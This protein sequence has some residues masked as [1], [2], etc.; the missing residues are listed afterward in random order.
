MHVVGNGCSGLLLQPA[1]RRCQLT[2]FETFQNLIIAFILV[3]EDFSAPL[4]EQP[5]RFVPLRR[6]FQ[7]SSHLWK[8][9]LHVIRT[10]AAR[11]A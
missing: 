2:L 1:L 8:E 6:E 10:A 3:D 4:L 5:S 9:P 7:R 11:E